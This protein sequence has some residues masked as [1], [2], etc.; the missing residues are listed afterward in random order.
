MWFIIFSFYAFNF[1]TKI[2]STVKPCYKS[3]FIANF[4]NNILNS[5]T[6]VALIQKLLIYWSS[7]YI[8][9]HYKYFECKLSLLYKE[10][11]L[12]T[13]EKRRI[14]KIKYKIINHSKNQS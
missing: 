10:V 7:L 6:K 11:T 3:F 4:Y 5:P 1:D 13:Q 14:I 12:S 9:S 2:D 8:D